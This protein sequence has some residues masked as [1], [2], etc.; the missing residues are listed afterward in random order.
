MQQLE[1][2]GCLKAT[3][4]AGT[5]FDCAWIEVNAAGAPVADYTFENR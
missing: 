4:D 2:T 3:N 1:A 5:A